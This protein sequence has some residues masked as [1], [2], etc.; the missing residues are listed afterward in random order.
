MS[1]AQQVLEH[2]KEQFD[3][4][5]VFE[6]QRDNLARGI[7]Q[8]GRDSQE[9]FAIDAGCPSLVLSLPDMPF[10]FQE[11]Q[12]YRMIGMVSANL[13]TDQA[14]HLIRENPEC[15]IGLGQRSVFQSFIDAIDANSTDLTELFG[16]DGVVQVEPGVAVGHHVASIRL[17]CPIEDGS[18]II[19]STA[20]TLD[21]DP[22]GLVPVHLKMRV[23]PP[24]DHSL[25]SLPLQDG[26][27]HDPRHRGD[28]LGINQR[29]CLSDVGQPRGLASDCLRRPP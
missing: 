2:S 1:A 29:Q 14:D 20:V 25:A 22:R 24:F 28:D 18:F 6:Q 11:H 15:A 9:P 7:R 23:E 16:D 19:A 17:D 5:A 12:S 26:R 13:R 10:D 4:P 27:R 21:I 8:I 3:R